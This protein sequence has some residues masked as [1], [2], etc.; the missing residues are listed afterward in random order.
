MSAVWFAAAGWSTA[1]GAATAVQVG[2]SGKTFASAATQCAVN[3]ATG[4]NSPLVQAGLF[5]PSSQVEADLRLNGV[6]L[7]ELRAASPSADVWLADGGNAV[8]VALSRRVR[9]IYEFSVTPGQC[10]LPAVPGNWY[11]PDGTLEYAASGKSYLTVVPGCALNPATGLTQPFVNLFDNGSF[12]LNVSV[13]GIALTQLS[14]LRPATPV[15]L[16]AG[17]NVITAAN[18]SL[19]TDSFIRDGGTGTCVLP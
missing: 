16:S 14:A 13:N 7:A 18:A 8:T 9:D 6:K 3:P 15:F 4:I 1:A 19:S 10:N 11:S 5:N 2:T 12:L 17:Q